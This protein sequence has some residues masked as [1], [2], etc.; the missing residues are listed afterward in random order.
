MP[1]EEQE[2]R[3]VSWQSV[4]LQSAVLLVLLGS[5]VFVVALLL[6]V[7]AL[8]ML[9]GTVVPRLSR[10]WWSDLISDAVAFPLRMLQS[11]GA[12]LR[13]VSLLTEMKALPGVEKGRGP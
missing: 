7:F 11:C 4:V 3:G 2:V 12:G 8:R 5:V 10:V 13:K 9:E 1:G 6:G